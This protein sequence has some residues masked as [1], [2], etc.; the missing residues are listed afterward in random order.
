MRNGHLYEIPAAAPEF[1]PPLPSPQR[2]VA[3]LIETAWR[4]RAS[5]L[6]FLANRDSVDVAVRQWGEVRRIEKLSADFGRH[7][8]TYIKA[9]AGVD[10]F[11]KRRPLDGR[12]HCQCDGQTIDLRI[13]SIPTRFGEGRHAAIVCH[14]PNRCRRWKISAC[15]PT[16]S[17]ACE[18]FSPA[19][20]D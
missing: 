12:W 5:D 2:D 14:R 16:T 3:R 1:V 7:C 15:R 10:I 4:M 13:S 8:I 18:Q 19:P 6:Y 9:L 11:E 17:P 20:A